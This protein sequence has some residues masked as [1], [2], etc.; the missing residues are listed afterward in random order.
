MT[1][2]KT[3][4]GYTLA[5][6]RTISQVI[7][8]LPQQHWDSIPPGWTNNARW[9]IGHLIITPQR[10]TFRQLQEPLQVSEE[11]QRWF[12]RGSSPLSWGNDS[13][14]EM[15]FLLSEMITST[16]NLFKAMI[17]RWDEP[18]AEPMTTSSGGVLHTPGEALTFNLAHDGIH[19][20]YI[21]GLRHALSA[22]EQR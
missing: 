16:E 3:L 15:D 9:H 7:H 8:T 13:V 6:R 20:G 5:L 22:Q 18:Y 21:Y 4:L 11:Y 10:L 17:P 14:P 19:L 12:A 1:I 2:S